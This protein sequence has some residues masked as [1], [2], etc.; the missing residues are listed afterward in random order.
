MSNFRIP[1][2][3]RAKFRCPTGQTLKA[4]ASFYGS[5]SGEETMDLLASEGLVGDCEMIWNG[6]PLDYIQTQCNG[7]QSC[8][9][10]INSANMVV[11][12]CPD[13]YNFMGLAIGCGVGY[14]AQSDEPNIDNPEDILLLR[15]GQGGDDLND[16]NDNLIELQLSST[17][18]YVIATIVLSLL[19]INITCLS[20]INCCKSKHKT[21]RYGKVAQF[22]SSDEEMQNLQN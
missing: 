22:A 4:I 1:E 20:Y 12:P 6:Q 17:V 15:P 18:V 10:N 9:V 16:P 11:D 7:Y 5:P 13:K 2:R 21:P 19:V 14:S 3:M 8:I